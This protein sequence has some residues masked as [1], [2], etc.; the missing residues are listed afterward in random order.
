MSI[1][2]G[3]RAAR[4]ELRLAMAALGPD[5]ISARSA[6]A[7]GHLVERWPAPDPVMAYLAMPAEADAGGAIAFWRA[8]GVVVCVPRTSWVARSMQP[9]VLGDRVVTGAKGIREAASDQPTL[10]PGGLRAVIVPGLGF[11]RDGRRLGRGAGF[12]DR[13]LA[14]LGPETERVGFALSAQVRD[15]LPTEPTDEPVDWL[16][17]D[18]GVI[19]TRHRTAE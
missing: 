2:D 12:Y 10:D 6:V 4:N 1:A 13:F 3:K 7:C 18:D 16:V 9:A 11:T 17:T 15:D 19:Q 5:T 14:R 8:R